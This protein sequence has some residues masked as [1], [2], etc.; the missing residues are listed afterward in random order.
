MNHRP[1]RV[2]NY[3]EMLQVSPKATGLQ[4][5]RQY[6]TLLSA[7]HERWPETPGKNDPEHVRAHRHHLAALSIAYQTLVDPELRSVYDKA[8]EGG[9]FNYPNEYLDAV[10]SVS[11]SHNA[12]STKNEQ[13][14]CLPPLLSRGENIYGGFIHLARTL[15]G[16]RT[17]ASPR[18]AVVFEPGPHLG[19]QLRQMLA[20]HGIAFSQTSASGNVHSIEVAYKPAEA[21]A[22]NSIT[23]NDPKAAKILCDLTL[24]ALWDHHVK[25]RNAMDPAR[26]M[27]SL[28]PEPLPDGMMRPLQAAFLAC[29]KRAGINVSLTEEKDHLLIRAEDFTKLNSYIKQ[30]K[31]AVEVWVN[32][33]PLP[34][35]G[36]G[37][38]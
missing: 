32:E 17:Q 31:P 33:H 20:Q 8:L 26:K 30:A 19:F 21:Q 3:Y 22:G 18:G 35:P 28:D 27:L 4:I 6:K 2:L 36:R 13:P 1:P 11:R 10:L 15:D 24:C 37:G 14:R 34:M 23:V 29:V 16:P 25:K 7:Y 9:S 5:E 38:R 12:T